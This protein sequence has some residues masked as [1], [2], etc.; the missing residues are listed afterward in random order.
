M[1]KPAFD[2]NK[3]FEQVE[4]EKPAF[5]PNQP[6]EEL[7]KPKKDKYSAAEAFLDK[8]SESMSFG[9]DLP[10]MAKGEVGIA[11]V[12]EAFGGEPVPEN[13]YEKKLKEFEERRRV[14][15]EESPWVSGA[16]TLIG[17]V[18]PGMAIAKGVGAA[19][20]AIGLAPK[21]ATLAGRAG[22]LASEGA[23]AGGLYRAPGDEQNR[24]L[25]AAI[26]A[27]LG[28]A[29]PVAGRVVSKTAS[30]LKKG[31][32]AGTRKLISA[33]G[34]VEESAVTKFFNDPDRYLGAPKREDVVGNISKVISQIQDDVTNGKYRAKEAK[35]AV[36][37]L[38]R[39][40]RE[41]KLDQR[42]ELLAGVR[43]AKNQLDESFKAA[44]Q[45]LK[46]K[47][48][49]T[50]LAPEIQASLRTLKQE[51]KEG[52]EEAFKKLKEVRGKKL[53]QVYHG[54]FK[55]F[56]AE[57]I[58]PSRGGYF[59][60]GVY[61]TKEKGYKYGD[62]IKQ[63]SLP[64][65]FKVFNFDDEKGSLEFINKLAQKYD[66]KMP[67]IT[68]FDRKYTS[69]L[70]YD[71]LKEV[72]EEIAQKRG[73]ELVGN[74]KDRY[75]HALLKSEGFDGLFVV[76]NQNE[77]MQVIFNAK[78]LLPKNIT[79]G[80]TKINQQK[81]LEDVYL[82]AS[83]SIQDLSERGSS[84]AKQGAKDLSQYLEL[85][86]NKIDNKKLSLKEMKR[87][88]QDLDQD[89]R[90]WELSTGEFDDA[91][92]KAL[93][94]LRRNLDEFLKSE[95]PEYREEMAKLAPKT[96]L[97][98]EASKR[99]GKE[100][101]S[102][103]R[104]SRIDKEQA[105]IDRE[106]LDELGKMT[107]SDFEGPINEYIEA[108]RLLKSK[109]RMGALKEALPETKELRT[110]EGKLALAK[111]E[112]KPKF[113]REQVKSSP[114]FRKMKLS[115]AELAKAQDLKQRMAG[116]TEQN[117]DSKINQVM[118]NKKFVQKQLE[119]LGKLSDKNF[120]DQ[121]EKM[122]VAE[123]FTKDATRGSRNVNLWSIIGLAGG[124]SVIGGP[125]GAALGA[126]L[127]AM[128]DKYGPRAT[129]QILLAASRMTKPTVAAFQKYK[130]PKKVAEEMIELL[131]GTA[132]ASQAP[133][134]NNR[135][136]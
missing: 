15:Q 19:R 74:Q 101:G 109:T 11:K 80:G 33:I 84:S 117:V 37:D 66:V 23:I 24:G 134:R 6:F 52:S 83:E 111:R 56:P 63:Y 48:A 68:D 57:E 17:A 50:E 127:G 131:K 64:E 85:I 73:R 104:L 81:F 18:A 90:S 9:Y 42:G 119:E 5:D 29:M 120:L 12:K 20:G 16:G 32:S 116:W 70:P 108:Q 135:G 91:R 71:K 2:P 51:V 132:L 86:Q 28:A 110:A 1:A 40:I 122:Q 92:N 59:G 121:V 88:I 35:L 4:G 136:E 62:I 118:R 124:G 130:V 43:A 44:E 13:L 7:N 10:L 133:L 103:S 129:K 100:E 126:A 82:K 21:A 39:T 125:Y 113:I 87:L 95:I 112:A 55:D 96:R 89:V 79:I 25:N 76:K 22:T 53:D 45:A 38:E 8:L 30:G 3:P 27:G 67:E 46:S 114:Q 75:A 102:I 72:A 31:V 107:G 65:N 49:P 115:D 128:S 26:G 105:K 47:K 60:P 14:T 123:A 78:K 99:F 93:K 36:K 97:L 77:P 98:G 54:T 41:S 34:N 69:N 106:I 61:V 94:G 58:K